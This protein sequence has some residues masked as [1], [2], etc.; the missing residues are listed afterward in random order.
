MV[1]SNFV[2]ARVLL[3]DHSIFCYYGPYA[4]ANHQH[5]NE[6]IEIGGKKDI[7]KPDLLHEVG[8]FIAALSKKNVAN[9][10]AA[11]AEISAAR[12]A[13]RFATIIACNEIILE[14]DLAEII[15]AIKQSMLWL[16]WK[17][18]CETRA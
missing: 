4:L 18:P 16:L 8:Y 17:S 11:S 9:G 12:E 7:R 6:H 13:I 10:S 2:E 1:S 15:G 5:I 14:G 3:G